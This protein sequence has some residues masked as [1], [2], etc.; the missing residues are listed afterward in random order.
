MI[1]QTNESFLFNIHFSLSQLLLQHELQLDIS[2]NS[3]STGINCG[4]LLSF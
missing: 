2:V 4:K 3:R 1:I